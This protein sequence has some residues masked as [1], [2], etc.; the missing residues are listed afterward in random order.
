[1]AKKCPGCGKMIAN[2][3]KVCPICGVFAQ[4]QGVPVSLNQ[5]VNV[6]KQS[7]SP[8]S[9]INGMIPGF[10]AKN[11]NH[12]PSSIPTN[13]VMQKTQG[14]QLPP[15]NTMQTQ[16][17]S[18]QTGATNF[19]GINPPVI[20][21]ES[22]GLKEILF[23]CKGRLNRKPFILRYLGLAIVQIIVTN[24]VHGMFG[25]A[26]ASTL[27][28]FILMLPF[29]VAMFMQIIKR[30][31]DLGKSGNWAMLCVVPAVNLIVLLWLFFKR[32]TIGPNQY[33]ADPLV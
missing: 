24:I 4:P 16:N 12:V 11:V 27:I 28:G 17:L 8:A 31:H 10:P 30:W 32:G 6:V 29:I 7:A 22:I 2:A 23:S 1:M 13:P 19:G 25:N 3:A 26:T 5:Q 21:A 20:N 33:G 14:I 9:D 15:N 18:Q